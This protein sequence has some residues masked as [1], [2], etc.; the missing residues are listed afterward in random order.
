ML[1]KSFSK[2]HC[3]EILY[4]ST[5]IVFQSRVI[6]MT[7][8]LVILDGKLVTPSGILNCGI[9]IDEGKVVM[10]SRDIFLPKADKV[11]NAKGKYVFPG[12]IDGHVHT[13][14]PPETPE[15]GTKAAVKGGLTHIFEMPG[16]QKGCFNLKE[17]NEKVN[18]FEKNSYIDFSIHAGCASGY[19]KGTIANMWNAGATGIKFFMA[20]A[21]PKWPQTF[22]G[23]IF[24]RFKEISEL[25]GIALLHS[26][27]DSILNYNLKK[28]R[29]RGR[30]DFNS[31]L[32][33]RPPISEIEC[34]RRM[35]TFSENTD[36]RILLVHT[37]LPEVVYD[38]RIAQEKGTNVS[39]E[40]CP[41]Y[42]YLSED[43]VRKMGPY[44]KCAPPLR[45]KVKMKELRMLLN[46]GY[47]DTVSTDHAPYSK[48][49]KDM[50]FD[51]IFE[52]PNGLPGLESFVPLM[53]NSVNEGWMSL[54]RLVQVTSTNQ[55]KMFGV[56]PKKGALIPGS[57]GDVVIVD[58]KRREKI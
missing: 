23:E 57:D 58:M 1:I 6:I 56:Y 41:Q 2:L 8:D 31:H 16:T 30:K 45:N 12:F 11:V 33:W 34:C 38:A 52:A 29:R 27:N 47:L 14:L 36:C 28:L 49:R 17:F 9:A 18:I 19:P 5:E 42:L 15:S 4:F 26:E 21:G 55:A 35:I 48:M 20:S 51:D 39:V 43:D 32:E 24:D 44:A 3:P 25:E 37:S 13:C 50:G 54:E 53:L 7:V 46:A 22:D 40:T 10:I